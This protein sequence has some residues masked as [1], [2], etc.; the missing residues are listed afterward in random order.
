MTNGKKALITGIKGFTG[1]YMAAELSAAG[2]DVYGLGSTS[3]CDSEKNNQV[4]LVDLK[5]VQ[6]VIDNISPDIVVHLAAIAFVG[7]LDPN[8]FYRVNLSGT[9]NLLHALVN[10]TKRPEAVLI[11]SSANVYG[12]NSSGRL[13]ENTLA[14][15]AN[16]YAVSKLAME[17]MAKLFMDKLPIVITRPFNYTGVGQ[18]ENFLIPKIVKHF[19]QRK[20]VI[21]LG[22]VDVW[23]DFSDVRTLV[24]SY[25]SLLHSCAFGRIVNV[26]SGKMYSLREVIKFCEELTL[27]K[28][29]IE[30]NPQF[31]RANEIKELCGDITLL[32]SLTNK[33]SPKIP[34]RETLKWMLEAKN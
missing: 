2:Y 34:L 8:A 15:P 10:T 3:A 26:A 13:S 11:A 31:V 29:R 9:R 7:H 19:Q 20:D 25:S 30:V 24:K 1:Q 6:R 12:N 22:N 17:Y 5:N 18:A 14:N 32:E 33:S 23:R 21:E 4:D 28:M 16:D 27:H